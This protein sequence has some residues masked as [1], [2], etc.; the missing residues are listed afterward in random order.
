VPSE[1]SSDRRTVATDPWAE[2]EPRASSGSCGPDPTLSGGRS[3]SPPDRLREI[4]P[5]GAAR[6]ARAGL[7][8][9]AAQAGSA[10][11]GTMPA[12][13]PPQ[14]S[15]P[16][17]KSIP[18]VPDAERSW[19]RPGSSTVRSASAPGSGWSVPADRRRSLSVQVPVSA[20]ARGPGAAHPSLARR[21]AG[22]PTPRAPRPARRRRRTPGQSPPPRRPR[23]EGAVLIGP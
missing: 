8:R 15:A 1:G 9:S 3:S 21:S 16:Q 22:K 13:G 11:A 18:R 2:V 14:R 7:G 17:G 23:R 10:P 12:Q 20:S 19:N 5:E 4:R 6:P